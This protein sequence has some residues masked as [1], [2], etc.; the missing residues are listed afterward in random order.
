MSTRGRST[1][2]HAIVDARRRTLSQRQTLTCFVLLTCFVSKRIVFESN[3]YWIKIESNQKLSAT[4]ESNIDLNKKQFNLTALRVYKSLL[5]QQ[6]RWV[7]IAGALRPYD[8]LLTN[9]IK[10]WSLWCLFTILVWSYASGA[11][12]SNY[13]NWADS[14]TTLCF[15]WIIF[16][17]WCIKLFPHQ[18]RFTLIGSS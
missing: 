7:G 13:V 15:I 5:K 9:C 18:S 12:D 14:P 2:M 6:F 11:N 3:Q 10:S 16:T 4:S 1:S 17:F 8:Q